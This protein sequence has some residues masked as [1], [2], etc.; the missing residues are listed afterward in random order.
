[1]AEAQLMAGRFVAASEL[2]QEAVD[3]AEETGRKGGLPWEVGFHAV[4]LARLGLLDEAESMARQVLESGAVDPEVGLDGAPA[5]LALGVAA[6]SRGR[7]EQAV[8]HLRSLDRLKRQAGIHEPRL[9]AHAA[10]FIEALVTAGEL[11]EAH[12]VLARLDEEAASSRGRWS[13]AAA[14]RCRAMVLAADGD[15]AAAITAADRSLELFEG[16]PMPFERSRTLLLVGQLRRRRREKRLARMSLGEALATFEHLQTPMWAERARRELARIPDHQSAGSLT[17]TE[18]TVA[19]LAAEGLTNREIA[20]RTFLSAKTVEVNLTRI[21]R[22]LGVRRAAL[23][24]RLAETQGAA[25][26]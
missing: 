21:Y 26:S 2:T 24:N 6:L 10:D 14:A 20:E 23:A 22:K 11:D 5:R 15:L 8:A 3:R 18:E 1:M 7:L 12:E 17:P 4:A 16:L 13:L 9:C 25:H 19:R